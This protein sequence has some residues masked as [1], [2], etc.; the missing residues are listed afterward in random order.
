MWGEGV[1]IGIENHHNSQMSARITADAY[2][3][4]F[5][6]WL[7]NRTN[8]YS[9]LYAQRLRSDGSYQWLHDIRITN[10]D[11]SISISDIDAI[12]DSNGQVFVTW[13][14]DRNGNQDLYMQRLSNSGSLLWAPDFQVVYPDYFYFP[15]GTVQSRT[16]DTLA[17]NITQATLTADVALNGGSVQFSLTN[18]G[19]ATWAAVTPGVT[20]VFTITG[21]DLR[22]RAELT[23][24]PLW[25]HRSPVVN[26]LRIEYSTDIPGGDDYEPDDTCAQASPIQVNGAAQRRNFHQGQDSDW[27]WFEGVAG[28]TY[29]IQTSNTGPRADTVLELHDACDEPP[30]DEDDNAFGP[31]ATLAFTAPTSVRY[32]VRVLQDDGSVY[33]PDT[34]YDLSVR[35]QQPT[36]AAIIVAGRMYVGDRR[37]PIIEATTD[38]AYQALLQG[39]F[40]PENIMYLSTTTGKPEIDATPTKANVRDA[41]QDWGRARVGLG[42]P[43]WVY[44]ADHGDV[45][46]FHNE[47]GEVI[48]AAE[49]NL[50]L[51]NL[52]ATSGVD[53]INVII[54]ACHSGSFIDTQI[55]DG[56][57]LDEIT[58]H[59]RVVVASTVYSSRAY[60]PSGP[61]TFLYFSNGFWWTLGQGQSVWDAF[62]AGRTQVESSPIGRCGDYDFNS[63]CQRPWLDDTG[64]AWFDASDG[65]IAQTRGLHASFSGG[66]APYIDWLTVDEVSA[67][68]AVVRAQVRDDS[69]VTRVWARVFAPSFT[70]PESA[71]GTIPVIEVPEV[72]LTRESGDVFS[73]AYPDFTEAGV[74]QVVLYAQDDDGYTSIPRWVLVG[75]KKVYLPLVLRGK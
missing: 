23:G 68:Q 24:D 1:Q 26:S 71:D 53:Q 2:K 43:L 38:W 64:D 7:D 52:E 4:L 18:N 35:A 10:N 5:V 41:I 12:T 36:G 73:V 15:T 22:W 70:P 20:H 56:Y 51:S 75:E 48:T 37:Q 44:L 32:Y 49:L 45:D 8:Y 54:D 72:E 55:L 61:N 19:G 63:W 66:I 42:A 3:N 74:Y 57:G 60:A 14:D 29:I 28:V 17:A 21:S 9:D 65:L 6:F 11:G 69:E 27:V 25:R 50:W 16:V 39:G 62:L 13:V 30:I 33:G 31:G 67:G 40:A 59:G 58:G 46:R 47:V 34:E